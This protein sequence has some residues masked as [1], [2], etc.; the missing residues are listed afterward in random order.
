[1]TI[2]VTIKTEAGTPFSGYPREVEV[3]TDRLW[4]ALASAFFD[5]K[6]NKLNTGDTVVLTVMAE[7]ET[8]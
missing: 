6:D 4:D 5:L 7:Q 3:K 1:M 8:S 2:L